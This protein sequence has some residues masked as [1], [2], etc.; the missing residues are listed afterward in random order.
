MEQWRAA[1]AASSSGQQDVKYTSETEDRFD[2]A[3]FNVVFER[4]QAY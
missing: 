1:S 4:A 3:H 2:Q